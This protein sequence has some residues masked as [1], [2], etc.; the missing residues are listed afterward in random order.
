MSIERA[1][2]VGAGP[3]GLACAVSARRR[4]IDPLVIDAG[5]IAHSIVRYPIGMVFF[6]TPEL[7]EIGDHPLVCAGPKPTREEA[8]MYYRG[9]VRAERLRV[10]TYT[11]LLDATATDGRITARVEDERGEHRIEAER[12][13]LATG[14]FEITRRLGVEGEDLPHVAH[15]FDEGHRHYGRRV[16]VVGGGNS[17]TEAALELF[18]TGAQVTVVHRRTDWKPTVKYWVRPDIQNRVSAGEIEARMGSTVTRITR[19][20]VHIRDVDGGEAAVPADRVFVLIGYRPDQALFRRVG[21]E[22]HPETGVPFH[23]PDTLETNV[24]GV[25]MVGSITRGLAISQIFIENGRFDG[26]KVFGDLVPA[27][28]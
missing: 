17:A 21:V 23:D 22:L 5:A 3:I 28:Q 12:M 6:T 27:P 25:H 15:R 13:I 19:D 9:V 14:Y 18:R 7:L 24:P 20:A 1:L 2:I 10:R 4:G 26:E 11:R 8:L 16:V